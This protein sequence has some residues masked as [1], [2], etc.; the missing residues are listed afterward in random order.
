MENQMNT[1]SIETFGGSENMLY[2][3]IMLYTYHYTFVNT[4]SEP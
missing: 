4:E 2:N 3:T 1:W